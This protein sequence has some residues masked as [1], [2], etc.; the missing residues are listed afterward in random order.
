M[1]SL[2]KMYL[3]LIHKFFTIHELISMSTLRL[4]CDVR[5]VLCLCLS[6]HS[7][8]K[9]KWKGI[10]TSVSGERRRAARVVFPRFCMT[11][12]CEIDN[13]KKREKEHQQNNPISIEVAL[14]KIWDGWTFSISQALLSDALFLSNLQRVCQDDETKD[15]T[16][17]IYEFRCRNVNII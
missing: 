16:N 6:H 2:K 3:P 10:S 15:A 13:W 14:W 11:A 7:P 4:P 9:I 17:T 8:A 1:A 5:P 12:A